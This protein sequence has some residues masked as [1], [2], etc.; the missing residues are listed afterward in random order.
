LA[1]I[2]NFLT[3]VFI[4]RVQLTA[5]TVASDGTLTD[6]AGASDVATIQD[7]TGNPYSGSPTDLAFTISILAEMNFGQGTTTANIASI[8]RPK[9]NHVRIGISPN[10]T[11]TEILRK[12]TDSAR[13]PAIYHNGVSRYVKLE[14]AR[15]NGYWTVYGIMKRM[16]EEGGK[17]R[18]TAQLT[19]GP[20]G[21]AP[22]FTTGVRSS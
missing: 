7:S 22:T 4:A 2:P 9:A 21:I 11:I 5:Q 12:S 10:A 13:L 17:G 8:D 18:N 1:T 15:S 6:A 16:S 19:I 20:C 14:F 3:G